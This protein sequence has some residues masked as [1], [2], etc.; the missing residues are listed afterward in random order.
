MRAIFRI[1]EE[2]FA[3]SEKHVLR[4]RALCELIDMHARSAAAAR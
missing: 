3:R 1:N 2:T 4:P